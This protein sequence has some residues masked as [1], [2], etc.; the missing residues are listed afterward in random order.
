LE[1]I[2]VDDGSRDRS[3]YMCDEWAEKDGRIKVIHKENAGL[4]MA[5]N[6]GIEN[7]TGDYICFFDSDD[8]VDERAIEKAY[9]AAKKETADIVVFGFIRVDD[10]GKV[11]RKMIPT[12][13]KSC[14]VGE[15][16]RQVFLPNLIE[17]SSRD[18]EITD[19]CFSACACLF[20]RSL[21]EK[22]GW[23]FVSERENISEDSY[24]L[25]QLYADVE[26]VVILSE[27]L[28]YYRRN[29]GSLTQTIRDDRFDQLKVFYL[30]T[31]LLAEELNYGEKVQR[32]IATL[33]FSFSI[34]AMKHIAVTKLSVKKR[35]KLFKRIIDDEVMRQAISKADRRYKSRPKSI[36]YWA[37]FRRFHGFAFVLAR[38]QTLKER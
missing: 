13:E 30:Q 28:Y 24:S 33:F 38:L 4:G 17:C 12:A 35:M 27:A 11:L 23:R 3:P 37:V 16:V 2:L 8:Y 32:R 9:A 15:E 20:A 10:T 21:I 36:L 7:A 14:Y 34:G 18:A 1:I 25:L 26:C 29:D 31:S 22:S 5:R 19:L 6:T